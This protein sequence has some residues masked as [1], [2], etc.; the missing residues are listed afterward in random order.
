VTET[1]D[2]TEPYVDSAFF[3]SYI[4]MIMFNL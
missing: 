2:S 1:M 3:Y 4:A